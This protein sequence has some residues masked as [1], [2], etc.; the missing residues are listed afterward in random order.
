M[1]PDHRPLLGATPVDGL[2]VNTGYSGHGVML[3]VAGAERVLE[4]VVTGAP[5]PFRPDRT[6]VPVAHKPH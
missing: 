5:N 4:T 3:S 2:Y 1:T 6:F